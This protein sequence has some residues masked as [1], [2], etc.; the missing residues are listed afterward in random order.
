MILWTLA[1][2]II[3]IIT[4]IV[5]IIIIIR[6]TAKARVYCN[7]HWYGS[8][9]T[10]LCFPRDHDDEGHYTCSDTGTKVC[11]ENYY[12][13]LC[14]VHCVPEDSVNGHYFCDDN[15]G[16]VCHV[17]ESC[18]ALADDSLTSGSQMVLHKF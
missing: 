16:K 17:G 7:R 13:E 8:D 5:I 14:K 10:T 1:L 3:N 9:C 2:V 18:L 6:V 4:I 12:G 11:R 15:G